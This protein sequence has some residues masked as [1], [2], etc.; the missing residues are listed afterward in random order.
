MEIPKKRYIACICEGNN[1][2]QIINMLLDEDALIFNRGQLI[3]GRPLSDR[4]KK[5]DRFSQ[6]FLQMR[7]ENGL[8]LIIVADNKNIWRKIKPPYSDNINNTY[9]CLTQ[10]EL[11]MLMV[12]ALGKYDDFKKFENRQKKT[13]DKKPSVYLKSELKAKSIK[14]GKFYEEFFKKNSLIDAIKEYDQKTKK[15]PGTY[16]LNDLLK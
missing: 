5:S 4:Y 13:K 10:P 14:S 2:R 3:S 16:T 12:C 7:Y 6:D 1:E 8:D 9:Y 15:E 11:E